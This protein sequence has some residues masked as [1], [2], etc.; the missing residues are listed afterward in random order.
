MKSLDSRV[1]LAEPVG[2]STTHAEKEAL[3]Q[4]AEAAHAEARAAET[5]R[6]SEEIVIEEI[7]IDG[8]C[9]VY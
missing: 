9:G 1:V 3:P 7:S 6:T 8:M 4:R 5:P 2:A